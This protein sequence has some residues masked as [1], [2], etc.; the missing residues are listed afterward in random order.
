MVAALFLV[1]SLG[2]LIQFFI[3]YCRSLLAVYSKVELSPH[4]RELAGFESGRLRGE[5][6]R[7]FIRLVEWCPVAADD[8]WELCAVRAYYSLLKPLYVARLLAP[9]V[10]SW[11]E[12]ERGFC[13]YFAAVA[14]DRRMA[15]SC[16]GI[17]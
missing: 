10:A 16:D 6:F 5:Q 2:A 12:R 1:L 8:A 7:R 11:A 9:A 3:S 15:C 13:T 4:A 17:T 14:L